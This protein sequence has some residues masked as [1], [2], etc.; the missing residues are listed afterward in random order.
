[1]GITNINIAICNNCG[2][3]YD[4]DMK[5]AELLAYLK[6]QG[7]EG[8]LNILYCP[9]CNAK[10]FGQVNGYKKIL[11]QGIRQT[12]IRVSNSKINVYIPAIEFISEKTLAE[13]NGLTPSE[14]VLKYLEENGIKDVYYR[15]AQK[16]VIADE[17]LMVAIYDKKKTLEK[18]GK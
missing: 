13:K 8:N 18:S 15:P 14:K 7:W 9:S 11:V 16:K 1:M 5:Q 2:V 10:F 17:P 3:R 4:S 6:K 12:F